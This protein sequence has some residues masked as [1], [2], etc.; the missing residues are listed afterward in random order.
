VLNEGDD[1]GVEIRSKV[2]AGNKCYYALGSVT[3]SKS[4]SRQ[5]KLKIH[6]TIIK[7]VVM[8]A[9]ETRVLKEKEIRMLSIWERKISR[10]MYG[11]KKEGKEWEI[12]VI[13]N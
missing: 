2:S 13:R 1:T 8:Y 10:K 11:A 4:I 5:Y 12:G 7:P 3:K 9:P 6:R